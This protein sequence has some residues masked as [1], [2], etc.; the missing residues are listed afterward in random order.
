[1]EMKDAA[2]FATQSKTIT[3]PPNVGL[4]GRVLASGDPIWISDLAADTNFPRMQ[5]AAREGLRSGFG[6]PILLG[7]EVLGVLE[8]FSR[9][10]RQRD[11]DLLDTVSAIGSQIGQLLERKRAEQKL[12]ESE[13]RFRTLAETASDA[14]ITIDQ[15]STII[16][17][18]PA[19]EG[20]FG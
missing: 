5:F 12:R 10:T 2:E 1:M 8:F 3:F 11:Q 18:N 6:F 19:A 15:A 20:V 9:E 17:V 16:F 14:I 4:P 7:N 13:S